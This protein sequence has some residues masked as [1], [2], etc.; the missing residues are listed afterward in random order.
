MI[1]IYVSINESNVN[2]LLKRNKS[3]FDDECSKLI[4]LIDLKPKLQWLQ[5]P[6]QMNRNNLQNLR[7]EI[8]RT[9]RKKNREYLKEKLMSLILKIKTKI[10]HGHKL[11]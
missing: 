3:W 8:S 11:L 1:Q 5:N 2:L 7:L 4:D 6:S 10:L 9:F